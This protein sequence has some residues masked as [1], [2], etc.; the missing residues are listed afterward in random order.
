MGF[1]AQEKAFAEAI[2]RKSRDLARLSSGAE[3]ELQPDLFAIHPDDNR[4][5]RYKA[6]IH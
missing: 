6:D 3:P 2:G 4:F 5:T 1:I